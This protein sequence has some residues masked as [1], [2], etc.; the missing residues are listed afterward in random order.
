MKRNHWV[1][2]SAIGLAT[3]AI[4]IDHTRHRL[5]EPSAQVAAEH[6]VDSS[7]MTENPCGLD[8]SP[9]TLTETPCTMELSPCTFE[10]NPCSL[11]ATPCSL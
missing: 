5:P 9:C 10:E 2:G 1:M 4:A 6:G 7:A 11:D 3:I 8:A